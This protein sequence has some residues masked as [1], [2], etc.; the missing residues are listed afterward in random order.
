MRKKGNE[1]EAKALRH[2]ERQ[3]LKLLERNFTIR[4][5]EIDLIMEEGNTL[6]FVEVRYRA[7][8]GY[9]SALESVDQRKQARILN[10]AQ[11]FMQKMNL[12][13]RPAR[14]DVLAIEAAS[15]KTLFKRHKITWVKA[16]FTN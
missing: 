2:L 6:V 11:Y 9:G 1:F 4:G 15:G 10:T 8:Q 16:A 5:G 3:G 12:W 14:F 13:D 7:S